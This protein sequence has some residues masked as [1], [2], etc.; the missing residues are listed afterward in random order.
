VFT[1]TRTYLRD[2]SAQEHKVASHELAVVRRVLLDGEVQGRNTHRQRRHHAGKH[3]H[4]KPNDFGVAKEHTMG[5]PTAQP[6]AGSKGRA[7][8]NTTAAKTARPLLCHMLY[9]GTQ[10]HDGVAEATN[11]QGCVARRRHRKKQHLGAL[12]FPPTNMPRTTYTR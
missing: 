4:L 10:Q 6:A 2:V 8:P 7:A 9:L 12:R 3:A 11:A 1:C 5:Q